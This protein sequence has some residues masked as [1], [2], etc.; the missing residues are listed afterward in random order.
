MKGRI[1]SHTKSKKGEWTHFSAFE[2][3]DN[4]QENEIEELEGIF[5]YIYRH[6]SKANKLN[7]Q[8]SYKPL[9][10]VRRSYFDEWKL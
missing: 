1:K 6:D 5:R 9:S 10:R 3:W 2:V 8:K 7:V 4:I